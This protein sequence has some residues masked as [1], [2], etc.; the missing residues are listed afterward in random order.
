MKRKAKQ[1]PA[2]DPRS[3]LVG[4]YLGVPCSFF[5]VNIEGARYL[6]RVKSL[7][8]S[9]KSMLWIKFNQGGYGEDAFAPLAVVKQWLISDDEALDPKSDW[10][11]DPDESDDDSDVEDGDEA[12]G[13]ANARRAP[14]ARRRVDEPGAPRGSVKGNRWQP[15]EARKTPH[16]VD[17]IVWR[18]ATGAVPS[19]KP[20]VF[21]RKLP[22]GVS[23]GLQQPLPHHG[24]INVELFNR[25]WDI[26][27]WELISKYSKQRV[28]DL[29]I[30]TVDAVSRKP[31]MKNCA[32]GSKGKQRKAPSMSV[33]FLIRLHVIMTAMSICRLPA[34]KYYWR[35][36]KFVGCP[37]ISVIMSENDFAQ[38]IRCLYDCD[39]SKL[40]PRGDMTQ[41]PPVGYDKMA[42]T[43]ELNELVME[44]TLNAV[45]PK[46]TL[47]DDEASAEWRGKNGEGVVVSFNKDKPAKW[48]QRNQCFN[49]LDG[50]RVVWHVLNCP[51]R[52][53]AE[54]GE[55]YKSTLGLAAKLHAKYGEGF[56]IGQDSLYNS[57]V[58]V[59]DG[60]KK[61]KF[62]FFGTAGWNRRGMVEDADEPAD[63]RGSCVSYYATVDGV[64]LTA[65]YMRD[66][67][68]VRFLSSA[69]GVPTAVNGSK[70]PR[71]NKSERKYE[72]VYM[73]PVKSNYDA[74]KVGTDLF[75]QYMELLDT[76]FK[77]FHP[78]M[79]HHLWLWFGCFVNVHCWRNR[80][81]DEGVRRLAGAKKTT[82]IED[83]LQ[84]MEELLQMADRLER[85]GA[86]RSKKRKSRPDPQAPVRK[87]PRRD[88]VVSR[89]GSPTRHVPVTFIEK[90]RCRW[91]R[92]LIYSGCGHPGC[93]HM[94]E[95]KCWM[96][97]HSN[98]PK[99]RAKLKALSFQPEIADGTQARRAPR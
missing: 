25:Q 48:A 70:K 97:A 40:V 42:K 76:T 54:H 44:N 24:P 66:N 58:V 5:N 85:E 84:T 95:G 20:K 17:N 96:K 78:W 93:G 82:L 68:I 12:E 79:V 77:S 49:G 52:V 65:T 74:G 67:K 41:P 2:P 29:K 1:R 45:C 81:I 92:K 56:V 39:P 60:A 23:E 55:T 32:D 47:S 13:G 36:G 64:P 90:G 11:E 88:P 30:G 18:K 53:A 34:R 91:C 43:S 8:K 31:K 15:A 9:Q 80:F 62:N 4:R 86:A 98:D 57:P 94:H 71:W 22:P 26:R 51:R 27:C 3:G 33:P 89:L 7:H 21:A 50:S 69:H 6:A 10:Y 14:A 38:G 35:K 87:S 59:V 99:I 75:G 72:E 63:T 19:H 16:A 46:K 73:P 28:R 61:F 37:G 83:T